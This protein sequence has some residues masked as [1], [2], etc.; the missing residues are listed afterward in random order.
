MEALYADEQSGRQ[1][2]T[3]RYDRNSIVGVLLAFA[4]VRQFEPVEDE[5]RRQDQGRD[6]ASYGKADGVPALR[7]LIWTEAANVD[8]FNRV[9]SDPHHPKR[10][11]P[12]APTPAP[13]AVGAK[14]W[15]RFAFTNCNEQ[16]GATGTGVP[17]PQSMTLQECQDACAADPKGCNAVVVQS[18]QQASEK[19]PCY[20]YNKV[21]Q[22]KDCCSEDTETYDTYVLIDR[23]KKAYATG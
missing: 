21:G 3:Q 18:S 4:A 23:R 12:T 19:G 20:L 1:G 8:V 22:V 15:Q 2:E 5:G 9:S 10:P 13:V 16:G 6:E 14:G 17:L 11:G 7:P